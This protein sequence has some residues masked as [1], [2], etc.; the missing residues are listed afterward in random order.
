MPVPLSKALKTVFPLSAEEFPKIAADR[1][2]G[3][4]DLDTVWPMFEPV[5]TTL[6]N[7]FWTTV[8]EPR[9]EKLVPKLDSIG[10]EFRGIAYE[11]AGMGLMLLD[12]L[13]P[14]TKRLPRFLAGPGAAYRPL[15][16]VGAGL[17]LPRIPVDAQR[18]TA[19]E[20]GFDRWFILDGVGFFA[21]FF[22][23]RKTI[24][25]QVRPRR[26]RGY[27][28]RAFDQGLGRSMWFSTGANVDR[29]S[30]AIGR[31]PPSRRSDLWSGVGL[32]CAYA[33]GVLDG[34]AIGRLLRAAGSDGS[35]VAAGTAMA[36]T[37]RDQTGHPARHTDLACEVVWG[38]DS[39]SVARTAATARA[40]AEDT[41][42][43]PAYE[44]WRARL[45]SSWSEQH[46]L[47]TPS[48]GS[49]R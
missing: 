49:Q 6:V 14:Y 11:G 37:L 7:T 10:V 25:Q 44:V 38:S 22:D 40:G 36:A 43:D 45:R 39:D 2:P 3:E 4:S 15:V 48:T 16:L 27:A 32:A 23:W 28:L 24:D 17:V 12:G 30:A 13:L 26:F 31:F 19:R 21:G 1:F 33:A 42:G 18:Y 9:F 35:H 8:D 5:A 34:D 46:R 47:R 41:A 29:I 20:G